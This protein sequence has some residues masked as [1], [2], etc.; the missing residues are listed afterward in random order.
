MFNRLYV[1]MV[2]AGEIGGVL[3][4]VLLRLA[5]TI[6]K[7]VELRRKV[8]SAMTYPV[9]VAVLVLVI[10]TAM[11]LFIIPMF[12]DLYAEL[13]G[14]LPRADADAHQ[15]LQGHPHSAGGSIF[16]CRDRSR[17]VRSAGGSPLRAAGSSGTR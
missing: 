11:L 14:K 3:D 9:V 8:K 4:S 7:Q 13:G 10:V 5:D 6:E 1:A 12:E 16:G 2:K 17:R 15:P